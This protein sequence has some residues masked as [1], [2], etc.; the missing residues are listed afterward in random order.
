MSPDRRRA[1]WGIGLAAYV[2]MLLLLV[3]APDVPGPNRVLAE[4]VALA[5]TLGAPHRLIE[6]GGI[7]FLYNVVMVAPLTAVGS[8]LWPRLSW[9]DWTAAAFVVFLLVELVQGTL[10]PH[11]D[12][13]MSDVVANTAG[14]CLGA[15]ATMVVRRLARRRA[16]R[17]A[18]V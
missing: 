8:V 9:R 16:A 3:L 13:S 15:L 7:E 6:R 14:C 2:V 18:S 5:R 12:G 17:A 11:R 10:L 4:T 1:G